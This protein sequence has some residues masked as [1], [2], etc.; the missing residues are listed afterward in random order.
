MDETE[1]EDE[2]EEGGLACGGDK[3]SAG[4]LN[5]HAV[6]CGPMVGGSEKEGYSS[7]QRSSLIQR[8][9]SFV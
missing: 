4:F 3:H 8:S 1:K 9:R 6:S 7:I 5:H 2:G